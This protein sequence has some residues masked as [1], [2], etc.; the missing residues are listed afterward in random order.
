[1]V[2]RVK[3]TPT[4]SPTNILC[5]PMDN[6]PLHSISSACHPWNSDYDHERRLFDKVS[7]ASTDHAPLLRCCRATLW[8]LHRVLINW[9]AIWIYSWPTLLFVWFRQHALDNFHM[10]WDSN[11]GRSG[12][13]TDS[14]RQRELKQC[15]LSDQC[16]C[17]QKTFL[18]VPDVYWTRVALNP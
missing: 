12:T 11:L 10:G 1:M 15:C 6:T 17:L 14:P 9:A 3:P 16:S 8:V 4:G 7:P 18:C 13:T 2:L 5:T